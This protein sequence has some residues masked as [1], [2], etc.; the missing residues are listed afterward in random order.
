M[1]VVTVLVIVGCVLAVWTVCAVVGGYIF[2]RVAVAAE[3]ERELAAFRRE[4]AVRDQVGAAE[5]TA[6]QSDVI[7]A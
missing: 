3:H 6:P 5:Q 1:D 2:G 4:E 7:S